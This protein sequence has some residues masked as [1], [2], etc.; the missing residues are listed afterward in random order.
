MATNNS[1]APLTDLPK[2]NLEADSEGNST[3]RPESNDIPGK[4]RPPAVVLSSEAY[5]FSLHRELR[6]IVKREFFRI[7]ATGTRFTTRL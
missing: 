1:F 2:E 3:E 5:L 4:C 6:I 7:N